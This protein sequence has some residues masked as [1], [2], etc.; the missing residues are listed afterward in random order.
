M[1]LVEV[2]EPIVEVNFALEVALKVQRVTAN[3]LLVGIL[4]ENL[5]ARYS[6][7]LV[8][9]RLVAVRVVDDNLGD[10][11]RFELIFKCFTLK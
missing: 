3:A 10:L 5:G 7:V 1:I 4:G 11:K 9:D 2:G 8:V 6:S